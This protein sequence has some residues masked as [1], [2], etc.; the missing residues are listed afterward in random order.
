MA[1]CE[2]AFS[3]R[4]RRNFAFM[5]CALLVLTTFL[6]GLYIEYFS[7]YNKL[8]GSIGALLI[9]ML[10]IWLNAIILLLGFELNALIN[11]F[12]KNK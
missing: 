8:Y 4:F 5:S 12:N 7:S 2:I 10:Y 9:L 11:K 6:F 1:F 3:T